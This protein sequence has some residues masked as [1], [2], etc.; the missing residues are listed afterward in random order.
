MIQNELKKVYALIKNPIVIQDIERI[1]SGLSQ[2]ERA[3]FSGAT[4][5][6]TG[7]AG[8]LGFYMLH[9]LAKKA[10]DLGV[11]KIIGLDNFLV[12]KPKWLDELV[13]ETSIIEI[14]Q[15]DI[16]TDD[17]KQITNAGEANLIIHMAS[18]AS[19]TFYRMYPLET[20][21]ANIWG[22]R[23]LLNFYRD[24]KLKGF[25]FF[26]SSEVYG[27]P[28][29]AYIPTEE[30]YRGNVA[31]T[32][33]RACYDEAKRFGE[34]LSQIFSNKYGMPISI[35]RPFN[36]YGPGMGIDDKRVPAD[37]SKAILEGRD[38]NILS[39]GSPTR[40]FCYITDAITGY[41]KVLCSRRFDIFNI[42]IEKPEISILQLAEIYKTQGEKLCGY[43]GSIKYETSSEL[44]YL[45]DS[46]NRR[47]PSINKARAE[48]GYNPQI[49]VH[50]GVGRLLEF[51]LN[52]REGTG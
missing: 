39:D 30:T 14:Y 20:I 52:E 7:C 5:L 51:F 21:D 9:V 37:F 47:C 45:I 50:E 40:T 27:D 15:F 29:P 36:N 23:R 46:P 13:S 32:G 26:S 11:Q 22:L 42:G 35:V 38:I 41:L 31:T 25:L 3:V 19:P 8:F 49:G 17:L 33:P 12:G 2:S 28:D 18:V 43:T 24:R 4:I 1:V 6:I 34:T 10:E 48:L 44:D 16:I